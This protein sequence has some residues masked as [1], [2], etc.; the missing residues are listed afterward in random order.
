MSFNHSVFILIPVFVLL[1]F[2]T[3]RGL[4][5]D[6]L[7]NSQNGDGSFRSQ[8]NGP[9]FRF[10]VIVDLQFGNWFDFPR[11]NVQ[12]FGLLLIGC[13]H[14]GHKLVG[15]ESRILGEDAREDFEGFGIPTV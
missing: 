8:S 13:D 2:G 10:P 9:L 1:H 3:A 14:F 5:D 12:S 6:D 11:F 15:V 4:G 7:V